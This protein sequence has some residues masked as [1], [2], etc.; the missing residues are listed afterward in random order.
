[1][2]VLLGTVMCYGLFIG[3]IC[4]QIDP[5]QTQSFEVLDQPIFLVEI[6]GALIGF[7]SFVV[8]MA[9]WYHEVQQKGPMIVKQ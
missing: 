6:A 7:L 2:T 1:M 3:L 4:G 9:I 8:L 5:Y